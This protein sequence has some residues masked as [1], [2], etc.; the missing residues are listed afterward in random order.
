MAEYLGAL[1][2]AAAVSAIAAIISYD[3]MR[4]KWQ[5]FAVS[6]ILVYMTAVPVFGIV[7]E[8]V[9]T[10][11][12]TLAPPISPEIGDPMYE[13]RAEDAFKLGI[14]RLIEEKYGIPRDYVG[15]ELTGFV[16]SEMRAE[17]IK[18]SLY[19]RGAGTDYRVIEKY[20]E[21]SGL[22]ECEVEY[23]FL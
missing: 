22:G 21:R 1:I 6:V 12:S 20:I 10:D 3:G 15:V 19:S 2:G 4:D 7:S 5:R 8:L 11:F 13:E 18:I 16:L 14:Q 9:N 17:H 23:V